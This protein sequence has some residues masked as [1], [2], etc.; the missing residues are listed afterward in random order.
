MFIYPLGF[1]RAGALSAVYENNKPHY[2]YCCCCTASDVPKIP[3]L[4]PPLVCWFAVLLGAEGR[5]V[6]DIYALEMRTHFYYS[7]SGAVSMMR[8]HTYMT[9]ILINSIIRTLH[10]V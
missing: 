7:G 5:C 9:N 3:K 6:Q 1:P 8:L 2:S 4:D 10:G